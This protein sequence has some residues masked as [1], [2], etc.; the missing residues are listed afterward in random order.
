MREWYHGWWWTPKKMTKM[1][2]EE[3]LRNMKK[4]KIIS[5]KSDKYHE[6][7]W[8]KADDILKQIQDSNR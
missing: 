1:Q 8:K 6:D 5:E 2:I 4:T 3:M 7:E